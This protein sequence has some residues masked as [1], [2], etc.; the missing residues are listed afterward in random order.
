MA[1]VNV[2]TEVLEMMASD[3]SKSARNLRNATDTMT[4]FVAAAGN[5]L[6]GAQYRLAV[7]TTNR[8][9]DEAYAA[10]QNL[11]SISEHIKQLNEIAA[12]YLNCRFGG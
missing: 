3:L 4:G 8:M 9:R 6:A 11:R 5:S 2:D 1:V 10:E 12:E 7:E